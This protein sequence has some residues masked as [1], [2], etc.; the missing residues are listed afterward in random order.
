MTDSFPKATAPPRHPQPWLLLIRPPT[1]R[2]LL[3][4]PQSLMLL[5]FWP[6]RRP[7]LPTP[8]P[9]PR[10]HLQRPPLRPMSTGLPP[11]LRHPQLLL[12]L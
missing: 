8:T 5:L 4:L 2:P 9:R 1:E 6:L 10:H 12:L 3:H 7:R 11:H